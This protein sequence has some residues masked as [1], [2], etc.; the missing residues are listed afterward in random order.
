MF[1]KI[2]HSRN[3]KYYKDSEKK[4]KEKIAILISFLSLSLFHTIV[5]RLSYNW[6][7]LSVYEKLKDA[8]IQR[9]RDTREY[10]KYSTYDNRYNTWRNDFSFKFYLPVLFI[11]IRISI[12]LQQHQNLTSLRFSP[13]NELTK[14]AACTCEGIRNER[15]KKGKRM[16]ERKRKRGFLCESRSGNRINTGSKHFWNFLAAVFRPGFNRLQLSV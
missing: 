7:L 13:A 5:S 3:K 15:K 4:R 8:K 14:R 16:K 1:A 6:S 11:N 12:N 2:N 9:T 10:I